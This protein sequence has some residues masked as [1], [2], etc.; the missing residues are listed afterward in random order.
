MPTYIFE[1]P[2]TGEYIEV[3][4]KMNDEHTHTDENNLEWRRV[5]TVPKF[6]I[7]TKVDPNSYESWRTATENKDYT[8][9]EMWEMSGE[10]SQKRGKNDGQDAVF[11]QWKQNYSKKRMGTKY[12]KGGGL[13]SGGDAVN[14]DLTE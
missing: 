9:G 1:N 7:D 6:N 4:Q 2:E 11:E 5:W 13:T 3:V 10:L 14:I 12:S 8:M